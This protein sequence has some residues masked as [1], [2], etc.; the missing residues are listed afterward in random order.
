MFPVLKN[1][2]SRKN[3]EKGNQK[4]EEEEEEEHVHCI[5]LYEDFLSISTYTGATRR[6]EK[7]VWSWWVSAVDTVS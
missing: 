4:E 3:A 7:Q 5:A 1:S 6:G 2:P